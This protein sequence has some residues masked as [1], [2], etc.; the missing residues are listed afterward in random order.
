MLVVLRSERFVDHSPA[1]VYFTLLDEGIYLASESTFYRLL[2][3]T[4]RSAS[5]GARRRTRRRSPS[6]SRAATSVELGHH[7]AEGTEARRVLRLLR[8]LGHLQPL[9]RRLVRRAE[10]GELAKELIADAVARHGVAAGQLTIHADRGSSM[11]SNP[12]V[13]LSPSSASS[14]ATAARTCPTTTPTPRRGSRR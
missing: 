1:Q 13:E 12:V 11:T 14:A 5:A 2:R 3:P 6:S 8:R 4:A 9:R 10:S 7:Q